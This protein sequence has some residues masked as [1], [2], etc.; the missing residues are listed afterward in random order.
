MY[1]KKITVGTFA[2]ETNDSRALCTF[3]TETRSNKRITTT[4]KQDRFPNTPDEEKKKKRKI[5]KKKSNKLYRVLRLSFVLL[6]GQWSVDG[7]VA[8]FVER[9]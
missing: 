6:N 7:V 8:G 4:D 2:K 1:D 3:R 5:G 9:R